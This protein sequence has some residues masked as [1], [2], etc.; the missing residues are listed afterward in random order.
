MFIDFC[1][2]H[3]NSSVSEGEKVFPPLEFVC[4]F[5]ADLV[6]RRRK[7]QQTKQENLKM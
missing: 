2:Q 4:V 3:K 7:P 5:N 1:Q 6:R